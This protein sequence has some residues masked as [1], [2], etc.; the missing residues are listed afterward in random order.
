MQRARAQL[1]LTR[2]FAEEAAD[3]IE[4]PDDEALAAL[5]AWTLHADCPRWLRDRYRRHNK[6]HDTGGRGSR[7][8]PNGLT[9]GEEA[10][11]E[12]PVAGA[13]VQLS[14]KTLP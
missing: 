1:R 14:A 3:P 2:P 11:K 12:E 4:L 10:P 7:P 9:D 13:A 8:S 6:R 5:E